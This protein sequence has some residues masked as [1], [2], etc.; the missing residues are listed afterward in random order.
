MATTYTM[1]LDSVQVKWQE[2]QLSN[3]IT[4]ITYIVTAIS[5]DGI[6]KDM[7][8][9]IPMSPPSATDFIPIENVTEE[10]VTSWVQNHA[11]YLTEIDINIFNIRFNMERDKE[12]TTSYNFPFIDSPLTP[13]KYF[14]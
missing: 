3:V 11:E 1:K 4:S 12:Y 9:Q 14:S 8:K 2:E 10:I 7:Q 13:Y 5:D 6:R